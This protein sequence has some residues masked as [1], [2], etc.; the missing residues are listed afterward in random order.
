MPQKS[1]RPRPDR[2]SEAA[3]NSPQGDTLGAKLLREG[4]LFAS[5]PAKAVEAAKAHLRN[6][7]GAL[8]V[9]A[10]IGVAA[11]AA[12][13]ALAKNPA[14][15]GKAASGAVR[16]GLEQSG[17]IFGAVVAADWAVRLGAPA[18]T[19]WNNASAHGAAKEQLGHNIGAGVVD[20][21]IGFAGGAL[22]AG[23]A[24]KYTSPWVNR[25]PEFNLKPSEVIGQK[26]YRLENPQKYVTQRETTVKDD[27]VALYEGSF[28]KAEIQPTADVRELVASGRMAVHTTREADGS[29]RA[30]SF[31]SIHDEN[32]LKFANLDYIATQQSA[33]SAGIGSLHAERLSKMV[34]QENPKFSALTLEM[35]HPKEVGV[36]A[37]ELA[38]RLRRAKFYDR[39]DA[40][41]TKIKYNI[42]DFEDP[43]YRGLAQWRAFVYKPEEFHPVQAARNFMMGEGGYGLKPNGAAVRE[44]DR[45]NSYW[46]NTIGV[47]G[48]AARATVAA[49][50]SLFK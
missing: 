14:L 41:S 13:G 49:G 43:A 6:D 29:L 50:Q 2:S 23:V 38:V 17:K 5:A 46:A 8:V 47:V 15:L 37:E 12:I 31:V 36:A 19:T 1:N 10:A 28:P 27:V 34:S 48:S 18:V 7:Q 40:P 11:G 3:A 42:M 9:D 44:F 30:F 21:G 32:P 24:H 39:L 4:E 45:A 25:S 26:P 16:T 20:Y 22:G 33:R 35:E